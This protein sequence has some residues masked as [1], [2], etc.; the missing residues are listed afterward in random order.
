MSLVTVIIFNTVSEPVS[1]AGAGI[2]TVV[3]MLVFNKQYDEG[4]ASQA[5]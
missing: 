4:A 5:Y 2:E 3:A 1:S